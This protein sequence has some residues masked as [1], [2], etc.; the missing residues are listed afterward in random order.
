MSTIIDPVL[1][2]TQLRLRADQ[3]LAVVLLGGVILFFPLTG[4]PQPEVRSLSTSADATVQWKPQV[5]AAAP[6]LATDSAQ[7]E[8]FVATLSATAV[9]VSDV[10]SGSVLLDKNSHQQ[11]YPASTTKLM[12][13]LVARDLY[14]LQQIATVSAEAA[15]VPGNEVGLQAGEMLTVTDLLK[16]T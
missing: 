6:I 13:A 2:A 11:R 16:A 1:D 4:R 8:A 10:D 12:T 15:A 5:S 3:W 14:D 9:Y 7:P